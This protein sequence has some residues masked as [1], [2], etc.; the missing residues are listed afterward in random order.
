MAASTWP[1]G[2]SVVLK[3]TGLQNRA[4]SYQNAATVQLLSLVDARGQ[5]VSGIT[6]PLTLSYVAASNGDYEADIS[7]E[8]GVRKNHRYKGR[9]RATSGSLRFETVETILAEEPSD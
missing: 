3:L 4:G 7:Y 1:V 5:S 2:N 9:I 8:A 6:Y